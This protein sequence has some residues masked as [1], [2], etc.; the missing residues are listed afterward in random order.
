[1]PPPED[2]KPGKRVSSQRWMTFVRNHAQAIVACDFCVAVTVTFRLLYVFVVMEHATR[3]ILHCNVTAHPTTNWTV[4]Q[5][6]EAIPPDHSYRFFIH[7]RD[8]IFSA[9]LDQCVRHLGLKVLKTPPQCPQA[10]AL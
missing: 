10:N 2:Q 9:Q 4:Q 3:R 1:M 5:R 7:D 8:S 6:R